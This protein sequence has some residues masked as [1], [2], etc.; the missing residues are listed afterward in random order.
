MPSGVWPTSITVSGFC[1]DDFEAAGPTRVAQAGSHRGFDCGR[2]R[3]RLC[4]LQPEQEQR[5]G[6]GGIVELECAQQAHVQR[7][8]NRSPRTGNRNAAP[9]PRRI[10]RRSRYR[11]GRTASA[12]LAIA[13]IFEEMRPQASAVFAVD[14]G[15]AGGTGVA[16]VGNDQFQRMAEQFD[17]LVIDRGHAG[18][19]RADQANRIVAAAD[20]GLEHREI[21]FAFLK[22]QAGQRE[23]GFEGAELSRRAVAEISAIAVSILRLQPRAGRHRRSACR[24]SETAR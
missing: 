18:L 24:R 1:A 7:R 8:G 12:T 16:L 15:A 17:M 20:A 22:M 3:R 13:V 2:M 11:R 19:E 4:V 10:R 5:D 21:A 23:Q 9:T 14:D 6:D